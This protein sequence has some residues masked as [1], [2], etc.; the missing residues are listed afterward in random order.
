MVE[1]VPSISAV[2]RQRAALGGTLLSAETLEAIR[3]GASAP[4]VGNS[5]ETTSTEQITSITDTQTSTDISDDSSTQSD[6]VILDLSTE[7]QSQLN[8]SITEIT[9]IEEI[10]EQNAGININNV[11][12]NNDNDESS[13]VT[14]N[15]IVAQNNDVIANNAQQQPEQLDI[16][17]ASTRPFI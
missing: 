13:N 3:N 11:D 16:I 12:S 17:I 7:A 4:L 8:Q 6:A 14:T 9:A 1:S 2:S 15:D 5:E 10:L